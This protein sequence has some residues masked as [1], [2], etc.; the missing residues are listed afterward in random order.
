MKKIHVSVTDKHIENGV[1]EN[2]LSCP[3]ALAMGDMGFEKAE[4]D[5]DN[6]WFMFQDVSYYGRLPDSARDFVTDF[7]GSDDVAPIEFDCLVEV[8]HLYMEASDEDKE[9]M[10]ITEDDGYVVAV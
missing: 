8:D 1:K 5:V 6:V 3:I 2:V 4:V 9:L 10:D 7:D